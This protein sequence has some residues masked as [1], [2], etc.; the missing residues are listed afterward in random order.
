MVPDTLLAAALRSES[1]QRGSRATLGALP[2]DPGLQQEG[3][4]LPEGEVPFDVSVLFTLRWFSQA[5]EPP[6]APADDASGAVPTLPNLR[7][8]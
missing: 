8:F 4:S 6:P 5:E 7:A 2:L 3:A 1:A